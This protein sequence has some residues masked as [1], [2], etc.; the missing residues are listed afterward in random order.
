LKASEV[1]AEQGADSDEVFL[2]LDGV[3]LAEVDGERMAEYGPGALLGERASLEGGKRTAT[4]TAVTPCKV[5][6]AR[7]DQLDQADL[8]E[9][10]QG[11]R[12]EERD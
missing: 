6:V 5:A 11:H 1:L 10:S 8:A 4:L 12:H 9:V 2:I 3:I 7:S